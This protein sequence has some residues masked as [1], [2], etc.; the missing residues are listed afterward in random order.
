MKY[1][2]CEQAGLRIFQESLPTMID[3]RNGQVVA[4]RMV[5]LVMAEEIEALLERLR[6]EM[7]TTYK[8]KK[9]YKTFIIDDESYDFNRGAR[10]A[11]DQCLPTIEEYESLKESL[12][13]CRELLKEKMKCECDPCLGECCKIC[14]PPKNSGGADPSDADEIWGK[15]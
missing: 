10:Y 7:R 9:N 8:A 12:A 11:Q 2:R 5:D 13:I 1:P 15:R 6:T 4:R 14:A 3:S